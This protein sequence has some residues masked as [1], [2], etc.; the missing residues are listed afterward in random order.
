MSIP[1]LTKVI[2]AFAFGIIGRFRACLAKKNDSS[3]ASAE[4]TSKDSSWPVKV[5]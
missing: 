3:S 4:K 5:T 1:D 2:K